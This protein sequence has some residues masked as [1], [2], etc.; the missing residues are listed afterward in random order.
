MHEFVDFLCLVLEFKGFGFFL[1]EDF[2]LEKI[3]EDADLGLFFDA[4]FVLESD[5]ESDDEIDG[6]FEEGAL[7]VGDVAELLEAVLEE[8]SEFFGLKENLD[9]FEVQDG[10][11][12]LF[13]Q[14]FL[15]KMILR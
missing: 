12:Q 11:T 1:A 6:P 3:F 10:L 14:R 4:E 8:D 2:F 9:R 15:I 5:E 13:V 7:G